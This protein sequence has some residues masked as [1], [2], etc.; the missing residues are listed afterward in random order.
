MSLPSSP[1]LADDH[2]IAADGLTLP[3][4]R[5]VPQGEPRAV[6]LALHGFNDYSKAFA[7]PGAAWAKDGIATYAYDQR[8]FGAAPGRGRWPGAKRLTDDA[9]T[10]AKLLRQRYPGIPL[11]LLGESMGG[12]V[13]ILAASG[14]SG[15]RRPDVDGV[16]LVAPAVWGRQTMNFAERIGLW[17]ANLIPSVQ[18][19]P[20]LIPV[21]IQP[22]DNFP[23]L[24]AYS[25][26]P[27][28]IKDTRADT[29]KG[30]VD[31]MSAALTSASSFDAPALLLYGEHDE[32]VPRPP[33]ARFVSG[34]PAPAQLRQ[35]VALYPH[36]Y[37]ML[38]RDLDGPLLIA[39]VAAWIAD[40]AAPLPS[41]A[42]GGARARLTG[43]SE[44]LAAAIR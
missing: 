42:D 35:R 24:R 15:T 32:I 30:L 36:G 14:G 2:M 5:W 23:M 1:Q 28:V 44:P 37:H 34:L 40:P 3:L 16:I 41:G 12:A 29:L 17:L 18:L 33:M 20:D 27:L 19:S 10:A 31:L 13:A 38:L 39:D 25:A 7:G 26:D 9:E 11:Y 43:H 21:R 22:S 8:G 4:R 6:V